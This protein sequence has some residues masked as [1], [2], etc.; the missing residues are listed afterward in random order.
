AACDSI[1]SVAPHPTDRTVT[2]KGNQPPLPE[3]KDPNK[4][5]S[6]SMALVGVHLHSHHQK[7]LMTTTEP[8]HLV[9]TT[10]GITVSDNTTV[11]LDTSDR[12]ATL[13]AD[14]RVVPTTTSHCD[15]PT[16]HQHSLCS[17]SSCQSQSC[18]CSTTTTTVCDQTMT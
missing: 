12:T 7:L 9:A 11:I 17:S 13:A 5:I 2:E 15:Q 14:H 10:C 6:N 18:L 3:P 1:G 8:H 16:T 4:P